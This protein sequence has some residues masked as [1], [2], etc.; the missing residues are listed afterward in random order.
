MWPRQL[1]QTGVYVS[2]LKRNQEAAGCWCWF[3]SS[4][5]SVFIP[6][7]FFSLFLHCP[8]IVTGIPAIML[9]VKARRRRKEWWDKQF[10]QIPSK[11]RVCVSLAGTEG[12]ASP[13]C[14]G[15]WEIKYWA[16]NLALQDPIRILLVRESGESILGRQP[17]QSTLRDAPKLVNDVYVLDPLTFFFEGRMSGVIL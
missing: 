6:L 4:T 11:P 8:K 13:S 7:R 10:Q 17:T 14:K 16:G 15:S 12:G 3:I 1:Q 5:M 2:H 9:T